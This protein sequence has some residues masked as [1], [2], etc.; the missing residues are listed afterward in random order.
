MGKTSKTDD[1][2]VIGG[3][4]EGMKVGIVALMRDGHNVV[5]HTNTERWNFKNE[6]DEAMEGNGLFAICTKVRSKENGYDHSCD[7]N[8]HVLVEGPS[9]TLEDIKLD[10]FLFLRPPPE[11]SILRPKDPVERRVS[12]YVC[13]SESLRGLLFIK[14]LFVKA[15]TAGTRNHLYY[16]YNIIGYLQLNRDRDLPESSRLSE[17]ISWL[18]GAILRDEYNSV[19]AGETPVPSPSDSASNLYLSLLEKDETC[20][21]VADFEHHFDPSKYQGEKIAK[22]LLF[23]YL[24][25]QRTANPGKKVWLYGRSAGDSERQCQ[26]IRN[27]QLEPVPLPDALFRLLEGH[28]LIWT[29]YVERERVFKLRTDTTAFELAHFSFP[30]H[31]RHLI[32]VLRA[33]HPSTQ[34]FTYIWKDGKNIDLDVLPFEK[35]IYLNDRNLSVEYVHKEGSVCVAYDSRTDQD[36]NIFICDCSVMDLASQIAD[37]A[38]HGLP[39]HEIRHAT[40]LNRSLVTLCPH[41]LKIKHYSRRS[42]A[43]ER[44]ELTWTSLG[45]SGFTVLIKP[46]RD[47]LNYELKMPSDDHESEVQRVEHPRTSE[48]NYITT[49]ACMATLTNY[50]PGRVYTIQVRANS[51]RLPVAYSQPFHYECPLDSVDALKAE[52]RAGTLFVSCDAVPG[53]CKYEITTIFLDESRVTDISDCTQWSKKG[54]FNDSPI[55]VKVFAVS[56]EGVRSYKPMTVN[57]IPDPTAPCEVP[58]DQLTTPS[59]EKNLS[60]ESSSSQKSGDKKAWKGK[61]RHESPVPDDRS[62]ID[63]G[64]KSKDIEYEFNVEDEN[65]DDDTDDEDWVEHV[66]GRSPTSKAEAMKQEHDQATVCGSKIHQHDV[67]EVELETSKSRRRFVHFIIYVE[68]I[69]EIRHTK[70]DPKITLEVLKYLS[71]HDFLDPALGKNPQNYRNIRTISEESREFLLLPDEVGGT[72]AEISVGDIKSIVVHHGQLPGA[73]HLVTSS[74]ISGFRCGWVLQ[75]DHHVREH[76]YPLKSTD[77]T[78]HPKRPACPRSLATGDFFC[79][80]GGFSEGFK[81][82]EFDIVVGVDKNMHAYNTWKMNHIQ[83]DRVL[84]SPWP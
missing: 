69:Y 44:Q 16:G 42:S 70:S 49:E 82:A 72:M 43:Y 79:G 33:S 65:D 5:Y 19:Y 7:R 66:I 21:D 9:L 57:V 40:A 28:Q 60:Q 37:H 54:L 55:R 71:V 45:A 77:K 73:P 24:L 26:I 68:M 25:R 61:D 78:V 48:L 6:Y 3:H 64:D 12:G 14:G 63:I 13:T 8:T 31:V 36:D 30:H 11:S 67:L 53:A 10:R 39:R 2:S 81:K 75:V 18:W 27:M 46:G 1:R 58:V 62:D 15:Y 17:K 29:I 20:I 84:I 51:G 23:T 74:P 83:A 76:L 50:H 47:S 59:E 52:I 4:G 34:K 32:N 80:A 22:I 56:A 41:S 38:M 35:I